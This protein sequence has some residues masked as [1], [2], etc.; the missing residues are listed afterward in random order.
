MNLAKGGLNIF[1]YVVFLLLVTTSANAGN[2]IKGEPLY[3]QHC[4]DCHEENG[5][6]WMVEAPDFRK[7]KQVLFVPDKKLLDSIKRGSGI[8]PGFQG[9]LKDE[10]IL[11]V[12]AHLRTLF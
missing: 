10:E 12:I 6:S 2:P 5:R 9:I 7:K 11:D 8:M 4:Y 1:L 3:I